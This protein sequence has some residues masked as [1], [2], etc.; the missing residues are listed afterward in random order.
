MRDSISEQSGSV[1]LYSWPSYDRIPASQVDG[2]LIFHVSK[3]EIP[4]AM[5]VSQLRSTLDELD[6]GPLARRGETQE[7]DLVNCGDH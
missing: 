2:E 3:E 1:F 6:Y 7:E 4:A 5:D